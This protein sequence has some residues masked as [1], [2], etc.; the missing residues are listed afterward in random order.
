[1][2][3]ALAMVQ[4][5]LLPCGWLGKSKGNGSK[6]RQNIRVDGTRQHKYCYRLRDRK[7]PTQKH[8]PS[9]LWL[10]SNNREFNTKTGHSHVNGWNECQSWCQQ[11][12][13]REREKWGPTEVE[14]G[15]NGSGEI[16]EIGELVADF[17]SIN[18]LVIWGT[19]FPHYSKIQKLWKNTK[20]LLKISSAY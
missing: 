11:K 5:A 6:S 4:I 16:N 8:D 1:M 12:W 20:E 19:L 14:M 13:Q 10:I 15:P 18:S 9:L 2:N 3:F 7:L 17:C